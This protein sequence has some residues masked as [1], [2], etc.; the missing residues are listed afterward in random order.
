[1]GNK[2][3]ENIKLCSFDIE[4]IYTNIQTTDAKNN[5]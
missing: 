1:M 4:N 2:I 5:K 3:N